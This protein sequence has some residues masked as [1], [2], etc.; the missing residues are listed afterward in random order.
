MRVFLRYACLCVLLFCLKA[1]ANAQ[2][3]LAA[4]P[5]EMPSEN[6]VFTDSS[7]LFVIREITITGNKKTTPST[8]LREL[9]FQVNDEFP[10][11]VI[12]DKFY[13]AKKQL[14]NSGLFRNVVV[15]LK[16]LRGYDVYVNIDV[17]EKWYIYPFP[18]LH[19]VDKSFHQWWVDKDRNLDRVNYGVRF[20]HNNLTGRGDKLDLK[21][22]D[23]F[24]KE[25]SLK[26]YGLYLDK[27]MQWS[28]SAG[29]SVG[30]VKEVNY[31]TL[32]NKDVALENNDNYLDNYIHSF[33][34]FTYRPA[35]KTRH[36]FS[37]EY[38]SDKI[39]DTILKLNPHFSNSK[40]AIQYL[41]LSYRL[42]YFD[43]DFVPYPSTGYVADVTIRKQGFNDPVNLWQFTAKGSA[44]YP[45]GEKYFFNLATVGQIKLPFKQPYVNSQFL[46]YDD[47]FIQGLEYYVVNGVV[48]GY[49]KAT[50]VRPLINTHFSIPSRRIRQLNDIP[51]KL[52]AK[53]F[54]NAGYVY[55]PCPGINSLTNRMLYSGGVGLDIVAFA[56]FVIKLDWSFNLLAE[57]GLYLHRITY[58]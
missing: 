34:Q 12:V 2:S 20:T 13:E 5:I 53:A 24:T 14:I 37:I 26:Y 25:I 58:F 31:M 40:N 3:A 50:V 48:G 35:I 33:L 4:N 15:S 39:A 44:Y 10:L 19:P 49:V 7:K 47:D 38:N 8:I 1:G 56:D 42:T 9:N 51:F 41:A 30:N 11:N 29:V 52:Y 54:V 21:F 28:A 57:N 17:D 23:G 22:T 6:P 43:V 45:L 16:S 27:K 36:T 46:G 55:N 32:D 18:F